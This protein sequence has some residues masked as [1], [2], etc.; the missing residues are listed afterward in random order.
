MGQRERIVEIALS[1]DGY[2]EGENNWNK[3]GEEY[4]MNNEPW[5]DIFVWWCAKETGISEDIIPKFAYVPD[6]ANWY[7]RCGRYMN[8][9][10]WGGDYYPQVGDLILF[11]WDETSISD[12]IGI[13]TSV[14]GN[15]VYT[16][17]GNKNNRVKSCSYS[18]DDRTI[19]AFCVPDYEEEPEPPVEDKSIK[20]RKF[21][22]NGDTR[23]VY[24]DLWLTIPM[25]ELNPWEECNSFGTFDG[26]ATVLYEIDNTDH[27]WKIGF[28]DYADGVI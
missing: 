6:T 8:S 3:Y 26:K 22:N 2:E 5:C 27:N 24:E 7:D 16:I 18:L 21:K 10:R 19:R 14:D 12:H 28:V 17:E 9:R 25:G 15:T 13:V 11:D 20:P 4:G 23:T 1:Q